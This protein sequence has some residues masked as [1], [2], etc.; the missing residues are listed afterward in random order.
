MNKDIAEVQNFGDVFIIKK[1]FFLCFTWFCAQNDT[2]NRQP[3]TDNQRS[4][5]Q[6]SRN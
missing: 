3:S 4:H 2:D 5:T 6:T 1:R